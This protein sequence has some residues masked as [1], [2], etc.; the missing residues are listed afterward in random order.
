[1]R[2]IIPIFTLLLL[3]GSNEIEAK[4]D[5][6]SACGEKQI[7]AWYLDKYGKPISDFELSAKS[8][9]YDV[10]G[11][12]DPDSKNPGWLGMGPFV[13]TKTATGAVV[14][15][16]EGL[17]VELS[18]EEWLGF[19]RDLSMLR[20]DRWQREYSGPIP[21]DVYALLYGYAP[22]RWTVEV[23]SSDTLKYSGENEAYPANWEEFM[24]IMRNVVDTIRVKTAHKKRE[25]EAK[26]G[27]EHQKR[28]GEPISEFELFAM[29]IRFE[30]KSKSPRSRYS[31]YAARKMTETSAKAAL[32]SFETELSIEEW[33]DFMHA[34]DKTRFYEWEKTSKKKC[35]EIDWKLETKQQAGRTLFRYKE[36]SFSCANASPPNWAEFK[37]VM[38][39]M[40]EKIKKG[41]RQ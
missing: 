16:V 38:D 6:P 30:A 39:D 9:Y 27:A 8:V 10:K 25:T 4:L 24:E 2:I 12:Y 40:A 18:M 28:F 11:G 41:S 26:L 32:D 23:I 13:M 7:R 19:M 34:L 37:K 14:K 29:E 17:D 35:G 20:I 1:M 21:D 5:C 33:L 36:H 3:L 31:I 22:K 15:Y